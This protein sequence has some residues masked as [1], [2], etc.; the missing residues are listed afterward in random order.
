MEKGALSRFIG[1]AAGAYLDEVFKDSSH[2]KSIFF[3]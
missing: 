2:Y 1:K 3:G